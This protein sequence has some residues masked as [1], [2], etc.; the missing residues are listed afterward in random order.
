M[1]TPAAFKNVF[2]CYSYYIISILSTTA[3]RDVSCANI[4]YQFKKMSY[5][6]VYFLFNYC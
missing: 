6:I 3:N 5:A 2:I 4:F 1:W